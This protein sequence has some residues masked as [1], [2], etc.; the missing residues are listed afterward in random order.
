MRTR[1]A[2]PSVSNIR[3]A[4]SVRAAWSALSRSAGTV[5]RAEPSYLDWVSNT[6]LVW[7]SSGGG[8]YAVGLTQDG[9]V[10]LPAHDDVFDQDP[11]VVSCRAA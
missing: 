1:P 10:D 5:N 6:P 4:A 7:I 2:Q 3:S 11:V 8:A 9:H